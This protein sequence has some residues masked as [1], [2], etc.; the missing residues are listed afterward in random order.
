MIALLTLPMMVL[1]VLANLLRWWVI[2]TMAEH[3]NV[4]VMQSL[5]LGVVTHGPFQYIRH[6]NYVAIFVEMLT[7]P[8]VHTA[9]LT[10]ILGT[11]AHLWILR[12][13]IVHEEAVL[14]ASPEYR[15][16]MG[17]KPRFI[18]WVTMRPLLKVRIRK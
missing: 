18:P 13:R 14:M 15:A 17:L 1:F 4:Q 2:V 16:A 3:W 10:A 7:I 11:L 8:L 6:P 9:Y 12:S 5:S